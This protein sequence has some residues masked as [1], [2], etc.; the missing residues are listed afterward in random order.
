M[1]NYEDYRS[2]YPANYSNVWEWISCEVLS[3]KQAEYKLRQFAKERGLTISEIKKEYNDSM[4]LEY[5]EYTRN[6]TF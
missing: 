5:S 3:E 1:Y 6:K 2:E 4:P